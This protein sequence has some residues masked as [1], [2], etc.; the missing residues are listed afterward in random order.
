MIIS[1]TGKNLIFRNT[2]MFLFTHLFLIQKE[3]F[4][5]K[6]LFKKKIFSFVFPNEIRS[7]IMNRKKRITFFKLVFKVK[8]KSKQKSYY[9]FSSFNKLFLNWY[10]DSTQNN[11]VGLY[12]GQPAH[13]H[14]PHTNLIYS[15]YTTTRDEIIY[16]EDFKFKG[17]DMSFKLSE[18]KIPRIRFRPGY[19]RM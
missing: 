4:T 6:F 2:S 7:S 1:R 3:P 16:E 11:T 5:Y 19:Q 14:K 10:K 12:P 8:H 18:V 17:I 15:G 13:G 9:S